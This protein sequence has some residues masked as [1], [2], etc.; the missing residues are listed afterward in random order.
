MMRDT[1]M[2]Y[3]LFDY[4]S[5]NDIASDTGWDGMA[6]DGTG[7]HDIISNQ[8]CSLFTVASTTV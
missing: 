5:S 8:K 4:C 7:I 6:W 2:M 1:L 3:D